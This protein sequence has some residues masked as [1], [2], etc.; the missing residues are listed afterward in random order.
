MDGSAGGTHTI[1]TARTLSLTPPPLPLS[2]DFAPRPP[3]V[4][5]WAPVG[6]GHSGED[7]HALSV[8][9]NLGEDQPVTHVS[10]LVC[11]EAHGRD[12]VSLVQTHPQTV[13]GP[14]VL[15]HDSV[16]R[17]CSHGPLHFMI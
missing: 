12:A 9:T 8:P 6:T 16:R 17:L 10:R 2:A 5:H 11:H 1:R 4:R 3:W 15:R 13:A 7:S 14:S